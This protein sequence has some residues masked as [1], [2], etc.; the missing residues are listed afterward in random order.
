MRKLDIKLASKFASLPLAGLQREF[1]HKTGMVFSSADNIQRPREAH[2]AFYGCFDWHSCVHGTWMLIRLL[3]QFPHLPEGEH[4][5]RVLN[6]HLTEV[7]IQGE[8]AFLDRPDTQSWERP[9]GW[10]WFLKLADT[11]SDWDDPDGRRW[12]LHV[13]PM[14]DRFVQRYLNFLPKLDYPIRYGMHTNTAFGLIF[15]YEY[16]LRHQ[17]ETLAELIRARAMDFFG[18]DTHAPTDYEPSGFDFLSPS[19]IEC[20][21]MGRILSPSAFSDWLHRFMPTPTWAT[22]ESPV[23]VGDR[24]DGHLVHLDGLNLSRAWCLSGIAK[25]L[26]L[27]DYSSPITAEECERLAQLHLN[28]SLPH[29]A[30]GDYAGE[31]WLASFAVYALDCL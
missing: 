4:I 19:L 6:E 16:A 28:A 23:V 26:R 2:P 9:Y 21:L 7:N 30:S 20:D 27:H 13:Q 14:A 22:F 25:Q 1:P 31:H 10:T 8:C 15:A 3:R 18:N 24:S 17:E 11:L 29:V 12:Y 5:R